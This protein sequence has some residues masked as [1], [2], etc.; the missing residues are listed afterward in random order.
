MKYL[1]PIHSMTMEHHHFLMVK[2]PINGCLW[3]WLHGFESYVSH[4]G[5]GP[6]DGPEA[7]GGC[8]GDPRDNI[9]SLYYIYICMYVCMYIYMYVYMYVYVYIYVCMC[10]CIC[11]CLQ[12]YISILEYTGVSK[13]TD[14]LP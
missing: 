4:R 6:G 13:F 1:L 10:M 3:P 9:H 7:Q 5:A 11:I 8:H 2:K 12:M 14:F